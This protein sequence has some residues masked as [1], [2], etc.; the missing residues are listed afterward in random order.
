LDRTKKN[1]VVYSLE[2]TLKEKRISGHSKTA[3]GIYKYKSKG[4]FTKTRAI[5]DLL[6][7][8]NKHN[9]IDR[10]VFDKHKELS[11]IDK[12]AFI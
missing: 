1:N 10:R 12:R 11:L 9:L 2:I 4:H 8:G 3:E 5:S 7:W 6:E